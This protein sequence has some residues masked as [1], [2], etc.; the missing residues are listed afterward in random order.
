MSLPISAFLP[1]L[2]PKRL[3]RQSVGEL[4]FDEDTPVHEVVRVMIRKHFRWVVVR[5]RSGRYE[6]FDYMDINH[7]LVMMSKR[8]DSG[9]RLAS[10]M[11]A[12]RSMAVGSIANCSGYCK[13][14]P[15]GPS[16]CLRDILKLI[17]GSGRGNGGRADVHRVPIVKE[18]GE[19]IEVFSCLS[20]LELAMRFPGPKAVLKSRSARIFDCR[21]TLMEVSVQHDTTVLHG[22][23]VMDAQHLTICPASSREL[24]GDMGGVVVVGVISVSDLK[25]VLQTGNYAILDGSA[26]KFLS[27]RN[28][29]IASAEPELSVQRSLGR[30]KCVSVGAEDSLYALAQTILSSRLR[31][32]FLS[33]EEIARI[34][35]VVSSRDILVET[36]GQLELQSS[37]LEESIPRSLSN[38]LLPSLPPA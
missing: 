1:L 31:R 23:Q 3:G 27:W 7:R 11:M 6:F 29:V 12:V 16:T 38:S 21:D 15:V 36:F 8:M 13:F 18:G 32:L 34:V 28:D 19:V 37:L 10:A 20:F 22:L 33:S 30:Y 4:T 24:S 35:G 14:V 9:S 26:D 17:C 2:V 5:Y 25:W